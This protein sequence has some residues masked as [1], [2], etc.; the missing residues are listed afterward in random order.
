MTIYKKE[1]NKYPRRRLHS[2]TPFTKIRLGFAEGSLAVSRSTVSETS[3]RDHKGKGGGEVGQRA[4]FLD[5][6]SEFSVVF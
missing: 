2:A 1:S 6:L 5:V 3:D 4:G